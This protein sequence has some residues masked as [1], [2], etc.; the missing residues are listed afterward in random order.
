MTHSG[1]YRILS[2]ELEDFHKVSTAPASGAEQP[3]VPVRTRGLPF[4]SPTAEPLA[5]FWGAVHR[6]PLWPAVFCGPWGQFPI[7]VAAQRPGV[8]TCQVT[9][10]GGSGSFTSGPLDVGSLWQCSGESVC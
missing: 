6:V 5:L 9:G 8:C 3:T 10:V 1:K 2:I 4:C 7:V